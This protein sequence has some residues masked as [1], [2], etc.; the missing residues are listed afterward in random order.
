MIV[1]TDARTI[2]YVA[3]GVSWKDPVHRRKSVGAGFTIDP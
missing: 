1:G 3:W 2:Q